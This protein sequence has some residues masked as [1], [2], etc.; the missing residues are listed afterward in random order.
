MVI[1]LLPLSNLLIT[2]WASFSSTEYFFAILFAVTGP[3]DFLEKDWFKQEKQSD[4]L[5][6]GG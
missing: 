6:D 5:T 2:L 4:I 1:G 3:T